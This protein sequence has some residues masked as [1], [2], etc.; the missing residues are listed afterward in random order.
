MQFERAYSF[1]MA[2]LEKELPPF[3]H[4]HNAQ[5][6]K[7][8]LSGAEMLAN[9]ENIS[10]DDLI[11][12]K[13]AAL[14]H[15]SGFLE[16]YS[17]H[18]EIS[19]KMS[20]AWLP[21]FDY[22]KD[23]IEKICELILVT[24]MPQNPQNKLEKIICDADLFY[25]GT[26]R[27]FITADKLYKELHEAGMVKSREEW[28][29]EE[30]KFVAAHHYFTPTAKKNLDSKIKKKSRKKFTKHAVNAVCALA[31]KGVVWYATKDITD[32]VKNISSNSPV[33]ILVIVG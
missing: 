4:Y 23:E 12:L 29:K 2:R 20:R 17:D 21:Q 16:T 22:S 26:D 7:D 13:T 9:S 14:F 6:T 18:E 19:C 24:K 1:L 8:V 27:F 31:G 28:S 33:H 3:L 25:L 15:D 5:H 30:I 10:G 11:I 32:A